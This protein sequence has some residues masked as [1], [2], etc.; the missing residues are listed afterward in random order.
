MFKIL[1]FFPEDG[2]GELV[3]ARCRR[4]TSSALDEEKRVSKGVFPLQSD[5][6]D[7]MT[8]ETKEWKGLT[9]PFFLDLSSQSV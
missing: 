1:R 8:D 2:A 9:E 7:H 4:S 6:P 5:I 3:G